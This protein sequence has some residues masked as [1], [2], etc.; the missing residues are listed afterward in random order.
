MSAIG[1][2]VA[3]RWHLVRVIVG[4]DAGRGRMDCAQLPAKRNEPGPSQRSDF[5][6]YVVNGCVLRSD[7]FWTFILTRNQRNPILELYVHLHQ[8]KNVRPTRRATSHERNLA[9]P[10]L[11]VEAGPF[12]RRVH[13]ATITRTPRASTIHR[14]PLLAV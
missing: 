10:Q 9:L 2:L 11:Y 3:R 8:V 12:L 6:R 5:F 14:D 7:R 13:A 1:A 4:D